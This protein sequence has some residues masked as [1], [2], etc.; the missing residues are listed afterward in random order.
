MGDVNGKGP[1]GW[2]SYVKVGF[3]LEPGNTE[4]RCLQGSRLER[5]LERNS[6]FV[7]CNLSWW[8]SCRHTPND[9]RPSCRRPP[10]VESE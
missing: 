3:E 6:V 4:K 2:E 9:P 10:E 7:L 8:D 5:K 1:K